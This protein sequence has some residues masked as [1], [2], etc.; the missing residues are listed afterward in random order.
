MRFKTL[1]KTALFGSAVFA[2]WQ[3]KKVLTNK[4]TAERP[5][6]RV[7][8]TQDFEIRYYP[9]VVMA[10][11][12]RTGG[13]KEMLKKG[14]KT[15]YGYLSGK[16]D[17]RQEIEMT[18]PMVVQYDDASGKGTMTLVLPKEYAMDKLPRPLS[19][20]INIHKTEGSYK[21][22]LKFEGR[23]DKI[24]FF[25]KQQELMSILEGRNIAHEEAFEYFIYNDPMQLVQRENAVAVSLKDFHPKG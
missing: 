16:N 7:E 19:N 13:Y 12:V 8:G 3:A 23:A 5:S 15:L 9:P 17:V 4:F 6:S 24:D 10:T 21:A 2:A 1:L 20:K 11:V 14:F 22:L 25:S 18:K